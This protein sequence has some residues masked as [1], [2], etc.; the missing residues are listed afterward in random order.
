[1]TIDDEEA[2]GG[3]EAMDDAPKEI[4]PEDGAG[5]LIIDGVSLG[6]EEGTTSGEVRG[7]DAPPNQIPNIDSLLDA[8]YELQF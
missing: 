4:I 5:S 2:V 1:M 7:E 3:D 6:G 8:I